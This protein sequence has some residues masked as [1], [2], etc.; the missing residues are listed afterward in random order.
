VTTVLDRM[1]VPSSTDPGTV[2]LTDPESVPVAVSEPLTGD[3]ID[4]C[5]SV[6]VPESESDNVTTVLEASEP[7]PESEPGAVIAP[8]D[9]SVPVAV[10]EPGTVADSV[11]CVSVPDA[12]SE[13]GTVALTVPASV[14]VL[15]S[16][17]GTVAATVPVSVPVPES[18]VREGRDRGSE[19]PPAAPDVAEAPHANTAPRLPLLRA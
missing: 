8:V 12:V 4:T 17:P 11:V 16:A 7:V 3:T 18:R 13:P 6:P 1:P 5:A 10:S 2:A 9:V 14:P 19:R 15:V